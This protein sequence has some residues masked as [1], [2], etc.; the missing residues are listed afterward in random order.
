MS[1]FL[2]KQ[3]LKNGI[4]L[5]FVESTYSSTKRNVSQRVIQKIGY[6]E[7]LKKTYVNPIEHFEDEAKKMS[8]A[9][10]EKYK[11]SKIEKIPRIQTIKNIGYFPVARLYYKFKL[12]DEF[13]FLKTNTKFQ[14]DPELLF[15][16]LTY[17]QIINPG[18]K[19]Y[20]YENKGLFLDDFEFSDDQMYDGINF[21]GQ[22]KDYILQHLTF[23]LKNIYKINTK[24]TFFD[25][26]N[27]YFEIDKENDFQKRGPE[28]NNRHDPIIGLGLLMDSNGIPL[29]YTTF[30]GNQSEQTELHKNGEAMKKN[31]GISGRTI[32][33]ADKGLNSGDNMYKSVKKKD[34]YVIGQKVRG[35]D[36]ETIEWI[37]NKNDYVETYNDEKEL[38]YK[39]KSI[40]GE[41][42]VSITSELN[43]QK[44]KINLPQK[45]VVFYSKEYADKSKYERSKLIAKAYKLISNPKAYKKK[46]VGDAATYIK[47]IN[48]D[49]DGNI[50]ST[51]LTI[52]T[53]A[54]EREAK[55]DGYYMIVTSETKI[56]NEEIINIYRGLWEIEEN[57]SI[58]KGVLK[59]RPVFMK[60]KDG[61]EAHFLICFFSLILLRLIQKTILKDELTKEQKQAIQEA[62]KKKT[63]HKIRIEKVGELPM[64]KIVNFM[65]TYNAQKINDSYY[66]GFYNSDIHLFEK[67]Y[68]LILDKH[69]LSETDI[70]KI[71]D[72]KIYNT[73]QK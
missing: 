22:K 8:L 30:P 3:N 2:R 63:K 41:F 73:R 20:E 5:S 33:V 64:K 58:F 46:T 65:R 1:V 25:C 59:A 50:I 6:V 17:S 19:K 48:Y 11:E 43:G 39:V 18:S 16:F 31:L 40:V 51:E 23:E 56:S 71:F 55:L 13:D 24:H 54:I 60:T 52:D 7:E 38:T 42:E 72:D 28:K 53:E 21:I 4:Y 67:K 37:L 29:S 27:I 34:G 70:K 49:K 44:V 12:N 57:F 36:K 14:F 62:N 26:T 47:E 10:Q 69:R 35:A 32:Y 68:S 61:I 66:V 15:R 9:S 45:R